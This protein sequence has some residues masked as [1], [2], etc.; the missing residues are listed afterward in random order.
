MIAAARV[1]AELATYGG[2]C[3][4]QRSDQTRGVAR[5]ETVRRCVEIEEVGD[6]IQRNH[7]RTRSGS[8]RGDVQHGEPARAAAVN[9]TM[10][11]GA[12]PSLRACLMPGRDVGDVAN[13]PATVERV[14]VVD[15]V[16]G[17]ASVVRLQ[18]VRSPAARATARAGSNRRA[19][20]PV[21]PPCTCTINGP[22]PAP[23]RAPQ[24]AVHRRVARL[25]HDGPWVR[26]ARSTRTRRPGRARRPRR[27]DPFGASTT[28]CPARDRTG[29]HAHDAVLAPI[30]IAVPAPREL[31][32]RLP[33]PARRHEP[34]E[35]RFVAA[36]REFFAVGRPRE[37]TLAGVP[38]RF[39]V[40]LCGSRQHRLAVDHNAVVADPREPG[41]PVGEKRG[42]LH[43]R[44]VGNDLAACRARRGAMMRDASH[45][46]FGQ[47]P[48][49][50]HERRDRRA[51]TPDPRRSRRAR[52]VAA[53]A[54]RRAE[55]SRCRTCRRAR[56]RTRP[57]RAPTT[58]VARHAVAGQ[59][60]LDPARGRH[61]DQTA[62][63]R[64]PRAV[65][66]RRPGVA[67]AD[68]AVG[69]HDRRRSARSDGATTT[70]A[71][72][73]KASTQASRV[74]DGDQR[75]S[76]TLRDRTEHGGY[77]RG[78]HRRPT[79]VRSLPLL[80]GSP[81]LHPGHFMSTPGSAFRARARPA[82]DPCGRL[83]HLPGQ[84]A[85]RWPGRLQPP[86]HPRA[87]RAR[88]H[89]DDARGPPWP[90]AD[91][92]VTLEQIQSLD[93][94]K[95]ENPFRVPWPHEFR[96]IDRRR[97]VRHHGRRRFPRAV[98]VQSPRLHAPA[99]PARR[100]RPRARQPVPRP[101]AARLRP[102]RLAVRE[103]A[104]PPD[105]R[106]PRPRPCAATSPLRR[107]TLR[108]WY[109]FLGMQMQVAR[110]LPRH[111]TVSQNSKKDIVAQ[112]RVDP[113]TL[114]IVP[115]GVDQKQFRPLPHVKRVPG[116]LMTTASADVPLKGLTYL[117]EALAKS[118]HRTRR[119]APRRDRPAAP[120]VG[121]AGADRTTRAC[122]ARSSSSAV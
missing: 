38:R 110:Q 62:V 85:L 109:G 61:H 82:G 108:R 29:T 41:A 9:T 90:V 99:R 122:R 40:L 26:R 27:A 14:A 101:R 23:A 93:L 88:P 70:S 105:H 119:R 5:L 36:P 98:R 73:S 76:L 58:R 39:C 121:G 18:H 97:G 69:R 107:L 78:R 65:R 94:Y 66:R 12:Q 118:A 8:V 28:I 67:A 43:A 80:S 117:I 13:A 56:S 17:R 4:R 7:R 55:R 11:L 47:V 51:T 21:G 24:Q 112:M 35:A 102:R 31:T 100:V 54:N 79:L 111:I 6:R 22:V 96:T 10:P 52:R 63:G 89:R 1:I 95:R 2:A 81:G 60:A 16:A 68:A 15:A 42:W 86:P 87:D 53:S 32:R 103:H 77:D 75:G 115:V 3:F 106:R 30:E 46:M 72:P 49:L 120:Q 25:P 37:R 84:P 34:A 20:A 64:R 59:R 113:D 44:R 74:P 104:A 50:P 33:R 116:R 48:L 114:H 57:R 71:R 19:P 91:A 83:P 45:G 92:P